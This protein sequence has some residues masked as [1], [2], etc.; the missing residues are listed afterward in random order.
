MKKAQ[1][2]GQALAFGDAKQFLH[3]PGKDNVQ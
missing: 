2:E 1:Q 3:D